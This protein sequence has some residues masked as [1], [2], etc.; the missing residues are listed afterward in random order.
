[1]RRC[2][3]LS[4]VPPKDAGPLL[5]LVAAEPQL[6]KA[7]M[8]LQSS[9]HP[10]QKRGG[11]ARGKCLPRSLL[12]SGPKPA[13]HYCF[14]CRTMAP[15]RVRAAATR[16]WA[17]PRS[18]CETPFELLGGFLVLFSALRCG[19]R[20]P[21]RLS[22]DNRIIL[23]QSRFRTSSSHR[24]ALDVPKVACAALAIWTRTAWQRT[25]STRLAKRQKTTP[26]E[27]F[28]AATERNLN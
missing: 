3:T 4:D 11:A 8:L 16:G 5:A 9:G 1:M 20:Q 14:H 27:V 26:H 10:S 2:A 22:V 21:R 6:Q 13:C 15:S 24:E 28:G 25:L 12:Q 17:G 19:C 18:I 7:E 23:P